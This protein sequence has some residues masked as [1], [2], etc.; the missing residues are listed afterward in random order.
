MLTV[1]IRTDSRTPQIIV[2][3]DSVERIVKDAISRS[4][5]GRIDRAVS[6]LLRS[7]ADND[8]RHEPS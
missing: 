8:M 7:S 2:G 5:D 3:M 6:G 4:K 1:W